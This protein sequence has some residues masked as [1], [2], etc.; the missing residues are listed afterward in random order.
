MSCGSKGGVASPFVK[1]AGGKSRILAAIHARYPAE[2]GA[3]VHKYAEPFVGGGAVL[4]DVLNGYAL[5][6]VFISDINRELIHAYTTI[7]DDVEGLVTDL[8][9]L[10]A[11]YRAADDATRKAM[12]YARR[13]RF[14]VLKAAG[15]M[16]MELAAL[17]IFLNRTCFNGL[18]R[19]N[20]RGAYNVPQGRYKNPAICDAENL[21]AVS[22]VLQD[23]T[24]VC[25]DY[26]LSRGF[27]DER[28]FAYFDPPYR[29]LS[30]TAN[31]TAY[32]QSGFG[33]E[34]Q[35]A[36]ARFID[37]MSE[38]GAWVVA[39]NSDPKNADENDD[40]FDVLYAR[41]AIARID[42]ARAINSIGNRRGCVRELLITKAREDAA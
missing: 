35:I 42:A 10:E 32:A 39:S 8:S 6:D 1:W 28:T 22:N 26:R 17:F 23:V 33:D 11:E 16:R 21:R 3:R 7:R 12:Y 27:I 40:F 2:L 38:R 13:E 5:E 41:H 29:P 37:A 19:V 20:S 9:A 36:L 14:N 15:D 25:G 30:A 18:Y 31:F 24:I 34:E 4:F